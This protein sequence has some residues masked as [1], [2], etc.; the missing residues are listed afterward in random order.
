MES[1]SSISVIFN[2][3]AGAG[4]GERR[5]RRI[6]ERVAA[7][8]PSPELLRTEAPGEAES[9][10][11]SARERGVGLV[12]AA[13]GDGTAHEV[14]QGLLADDG[15]QGGATFGYLPLGT[16]CDFARG[17][18][19][20]E[21]PERIGRNLPCGR[22]VDVDVGEIEFDGD[23]VYFLNAANLGLGPAVART[24]GGSGWLRRLGRS[25]YLLAAVR[26]LW[27]AES[28]ELEWSRDGGGREVSPLLNL[29]IC[30]G[31]SFGGGMRPCPD[32]GLRTGALDV[33]FVGPM[34]VPAALMEIPRLM[35]GSR[36][37]HPAVRLFR[38]RELTLGTAGL[39]VET[40]GEDA[41]RTP[42]SVRVRAAGLRV[43]VPG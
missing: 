36:L 25:A 41:G 24:V 21:E 31:P 33:A 12:V 32:A 9:L 35:R 23:R 6:R 20:A 38:C 15:D 28:V 43:R 34:G 1:P 39:P 19:L 22:D 13:G 26:A 30:N 40:D 7:W 8:S 29:S 18:G 16:G 17:L 42:A 3:A 11:R 10:A 2:P 27:T 4:R 37:R 14:V 5:W